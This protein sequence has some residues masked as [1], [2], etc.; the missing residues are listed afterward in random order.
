VE[1]FFKS[2]SIFGTKEKHYQPKEDGMLVVTLTLN[3]IK[4]DII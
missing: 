2:E 3:K 4:K 1:W